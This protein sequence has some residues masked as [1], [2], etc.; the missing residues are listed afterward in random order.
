MLESKEKP[1]GKVRGDH[2]ERGDLVVAHLR[3]GVYRGR[4]VPGQRLIEADLTAELGVSRG[5][6]REAFR[7]LAAEGTLEIVPNRGALV[8]RLSRNDAVE[9][10]EIRLELEALAARRAAGAAGP[11]RKRFVSDVSFIH[12][13]TP[14]LSALAYIAENQRFHGAMFELAGNR[15]LVQLNTQLQLS[16]IMAQISTSLTPEILATSMRE[17]RMI[18][19]TIGRG[20]VEAADREVRAHLARARDMIVG[21]PAAMFRQNI[22]G[23]VTPED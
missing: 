11:A 7:R 16:L 5:L 4:Y 17:H 2:G 9:L 23:D 8:R 22:A 13:K 14:R 18:A 19:D 12:D 1:G 20:D 6:L 21:M 3:D 10:F 15:Q